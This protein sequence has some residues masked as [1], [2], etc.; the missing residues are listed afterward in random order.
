MITKLTERSCL[1]ILRLIDLCSVSVKIQFDSGYLQKDDFEKYNQRLA[2]LAR[3]EKWRD[4]SFSRYMTEQEAADLRWCLNI[5]K[6][7]AQEAHKE[8]KI[9]DSLIEELISLPQDAR[10]RKALFDS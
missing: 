8:K 10:V 9:T 3:L 5:G 7:A 4:S 2:K 6:Q 1:E